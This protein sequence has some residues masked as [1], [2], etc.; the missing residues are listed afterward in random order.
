MTGRTRI[1][2]ATLFAVFAS[3]VTKMHDP[4]FTK[5]DFEVD[6]EGRAAGLTSRT[7]SK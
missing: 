4:V 2:F 7:I 5:I 3:T 6:V 1:P